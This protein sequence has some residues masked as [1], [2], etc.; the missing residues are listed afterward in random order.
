MRHLRIILFGVSTLL[1]GVASSF[2]ADLAFAKRAYEHGDYAV[3]AT[4]FL[5]LAEEGSGEAQ[6]AIGRM[7]MMGRG[8]ALDRTQGITWLSAAASG[9]NATAQFVLGAMYL[10]PQTDVAEGLKWLLL[11]AEQ[12]MQDAQYLLGKSYLQG[13][14]TL[15]RDPVQGL[16]WLRLAA[17]ENQLSYQNELR[18]AEREMTADQIAKANALAAVWRPVSNRLAPSKP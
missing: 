13:N 3:A 14:Q 16:K 18:A 9:G 17:R 5:V 8:V 10:L 1:I 12:G 2:A 7:Y 6:L 4:H 15:P 11:S